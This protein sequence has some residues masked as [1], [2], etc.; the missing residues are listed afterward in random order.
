ME[1]GKVFASI[2]GSVAKDKEELYLQTERAYC[3]PGHADT[4][5]SIRQTYP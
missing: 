1:S 2:Q 5:C 3:F 4:D